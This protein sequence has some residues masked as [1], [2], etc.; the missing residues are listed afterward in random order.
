MNKALIIAALFCVAG[1][2]YANGPHYYVNGTSIPY[3]GPH[4]YSGDKSIAVQFA[5]ESPWPD[6]SEV[7]K[8]IYIDPTYPFIVD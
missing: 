2:A 3:M 4:Y 6:D 8:D 7:L 1:D 5:E